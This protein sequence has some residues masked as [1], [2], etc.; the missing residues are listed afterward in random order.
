MTISDADE[1]QLVADAQAGDALSFGELYR[2]TNTEVARAASQKL[3]KLVGHS[4]YDLVADLV[5]DTYVRAWRRIS[6]YENQGKSLTAWLCV[7]AT[8][9]TVD[10]FKCGWG[11]YERTNTA[12]GDAAAGGEHSTWFD[13]PDLAERGPE[14]LAETALMM[15]W[16]MSVLE[17][18]NP[19]QR[20]A[21]LRRFYFG[22][23]GQE[24]A[25]AM[26]IQVGAYKTLVHRALKSARSRAG[27]V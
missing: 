21:L 8:N 3:R 2:R 16:L 24:A 17:S 19:Y 18:V 11:R 5:A 23:T 20:E 7:I 12:V 1:S 4:D 27:V 14:H 25:A 9:L 10:H 13:R 15:D 22:Q 6:T 26:G